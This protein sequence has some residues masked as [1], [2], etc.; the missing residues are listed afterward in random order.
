[1]SMSKI[2]SIAGMAVSALVFL[3]FVLDMALGIPFGGANSTMNICFI[4]VSLIL[5]YMS[6]SSWREA[7]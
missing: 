4:V 7:V 2:L 3:V 6:W 1:M 5:A